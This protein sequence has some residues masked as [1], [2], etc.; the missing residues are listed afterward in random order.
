MDSH[1]TPNKENRSALKTTSQSYL[2]R[3][4]ESGHRPTP[5]SDLTI[6]REN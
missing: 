1:H 4:P 3:T 2:K 5:S 6:L